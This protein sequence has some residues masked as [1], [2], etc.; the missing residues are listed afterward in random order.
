MKG[1]R[2]GKKDANTKTTQRCVI[3]EETEVFGVKPLRRPPSGNQSTIQSV[4]I[5]RLAR[6]PLS[7]IYPMY[8]SPPNSYS[9]KASQNHVLS[10]SSEIPQQAP[11]CICHPWLLPILPSSTKTSLNILKRVW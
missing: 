4:G 2:V 1:K 11:C 6:N 8:L 9:N 10:S 3:E 5:H 7:L